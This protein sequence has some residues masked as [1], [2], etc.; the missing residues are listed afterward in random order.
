MLERRKHGR[1]RS[2]LGGRISYGNGSCVVNCLV[3][4]YAEEGALLDLSS[5]GTM[6]S[7]F[8]LDIVRKDVRVHARMAWRTA[9]RMGVRFVAATEAA[10]IP[11]GVGRRLRELESANDA[12]RRRLGQLG[13][14][15]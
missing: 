13:A 2:Y 11:F 9:D 5:T 12:L 8:D 15:E 6:P 14:Y 1:M 10:P 7:D 4:N 3:R